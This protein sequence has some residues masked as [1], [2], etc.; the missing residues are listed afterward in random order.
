MNLNNLLI[1]EA[2][3]KIQTSKCGFITSHHLACMIDEIL[4]SDFNSIAGDRDL[5]L[6][7][8]GGY[9]RKELAPF[10]DIDI[11][12]LAKRRD[13]ASSEGAERVLYSFWD[14]GIN[15]S[16]SFRT[17]SETLEDAMKDLQTRT[18][19]IDCRFLA[20]SGQLWRDFLSEA[21][22][23]IINKKKRDFV[24]AL[25]REVSR[26]YKNYS[27]SLY[28]LEPNIKEGRGGLRDYH[29]LL[30]LCRVTQGIKGLSE[31][32][33]LMDTKEFRY[34]NRACEFILRARIGLHILS[35]AKNEVISFEYQDALSK[36]MGF[37][38]T[39]RFLSSE[40]FMRVYYR[41]TRTIMEAL[42]KVI[43][44]SS[45][46]LFDR[47]TPMFVKR[48]TDN[49][50]LSKNEIILNK[51]S[52]LKEQTILLEAFYV[53][54]LTGKE[55]S[56]SLQNS[57]RKRQNLLGKRRKISAESI[58]YFIKILISQR[59]YETLYEMHRLNILDR[60][61]PDFGRLRHLVIHEPYHRY[62]V[63]EH[64]LRAIKHLEALISNKEQRYP[65]LGTISRDISPIVL[66][67]ALL[68]HD[69]GKGIYGSSL[70]HEG[71]GYKRIKALLEEFNLPIDSRRMI[72]F[73][74]K[75]HLLLSRFAFTRD[76]ETLETILHIVDIVGNERNL[77][78]LLLITYADMAAV[79]PEFFSNWKAKMLFDLYMRTL[80]HMRGITNQVALSANTGWFV[81]NMPEHYLLSTPP[82]DI[83]QDSVLFSRAVSGEPAVEIREKGLG[84]VEL[85][86][87]AYDAKCLFLKIV[88]QIGAVG[89]NILKA[90]LYPAKN[91]MVL[92]KIILS[93]VESVKGEGLTE[94]LIKNIQQSLSSDIKILG[95]LNRDNYKENF[96]TTAAMLPSHLVNLEPFVEIDNETSTANS[97]IELF[98]ADRIGLLY[99]IAKILS[100][101]E[102]D[103]TYAVINT[104]DKIAQDVFYIQQK[105]RQ[106]EG[107]EALKLLRALHFI[108]SS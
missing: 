105:G 40:I 59:V 50:S 90:R 28:Q 21:H 31:L 41:H 53:Y 61:L 34:F 35:K 55:F 69:I 80:E 74:V 30:W 23:R 1:K 65:M 39:S 15:I 106:L 93:N 29:T 75:N 103:I 66:Y 42:R 76:T 57:I 95:E 19:L 4:I 108:V 82:E 8:I 79:N 16:H 22:Q 13:N 83:E 9:G 101:F 81:S 45:Q 97:I 47:F 44:L 12:L 46:R 27:L 6:V 24:K 104:E 32:K 70:K 2:L 94:S 60:L 91:E 26:R 11:M 88:E 63:D 51:N 84:T 5:A 48:V 73:L 86:V 96:T 7:A 49:F 18:S 14:R 54:A 20:G 85:V 71:E 62:T 43:N 98:A 107:K 64:T 67:I 72:E 89:I 78:A 37:K 100:L 68:L 87:A 92:D 77:K 10:S 36:L 58:S 38:K 52:E 99:D 17:I 33:T 25:L 3:S 56:S 102:V